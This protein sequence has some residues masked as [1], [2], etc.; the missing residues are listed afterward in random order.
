MNLQAS[1]A[2]HDKQK[3]YTHKNRSMHCHIDEIDKCLFD[4][5][6]FLF[7]LDATEQRKQFVCWQTSIA[8]DYVEV[9]F[10]GDRVSS[11]PVTREEG[12]MAR[13]VPVFS[14]LLWTTVIVN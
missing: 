7:T 3:V 5:K 9:I 10:V 14:G 4:T 13:E 11:F 2:N 6:A 8:N 12:T 1:R